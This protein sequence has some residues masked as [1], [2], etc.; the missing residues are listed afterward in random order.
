EGKIDLIEGKQ[1]VTNSGLYYLCQVAGGIKDG[2]NAKLFQDIEA[3]VGEQSK[4]TYEDTSL[5]VCQ[6]S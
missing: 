6:E 4:I 1:D 3:K 2:M 5:K